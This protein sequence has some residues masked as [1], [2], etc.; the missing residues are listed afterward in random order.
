MPSF[1]FPTVREHFDA[2]IGARGAAAL[3]RWK[4]LYAAYRQEFA[5]L[6]TEIDQMERR[7]LPTG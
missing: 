6:A 7:E 1:S 4:T 5:D 3:D 2:E